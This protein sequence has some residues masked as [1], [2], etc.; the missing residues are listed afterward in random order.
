[1]STIYQL[2]ISL[3]DSLPPIWRQFYIHS[4]VLLSDLHHIIQIIMG[5]ENSHLHQYKH[6][7]TFYGIPDDYDEL[8]TIDDR[9]IKLEDLSLKKG[10]FFFYEYDFGDGW[11][12]RIEL[13]SIN[14]NIDLPQIP[15]CEKGN[16]ACPPEDCGGIFGYE[17]L[18]KIL[19]NPKDEEYKEIKMWLGRDYDPEEFNLS[20]INSRL[21]S[22][23]R[24]NKYF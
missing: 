20:I 23:T 3:V 2:R 9:N 21:D 24:L 6:N 13:K 7:N 1:M 22:H 8:G 11:K 12:H 16:K 19:S 14:D 10:D 5:W 15:Y 17:N 18:I 4:D